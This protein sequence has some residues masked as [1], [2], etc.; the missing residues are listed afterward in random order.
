M[1]VHYGSAL[2][3]LTAEQKEEQASRSQSYARRNQR[4]HVYLTD[5]RQLK[6]L[7]MGIH[8]YRT[9]A[10]NVFDEDQKAVTVKVGEEK[11]KEEDIERSRQASRVNGETSSLQNG[12]TVLQR[13][14]LIH[15]T[16]GKFKS[17]GTLPS[18]TKMIRE[19]QTRVIRSR[20]GVSFSGDV[21]PR[22]LDE[23]VEWALKEKN[24]S[25]LLQ[26]LFS[27]DDQMTRYRK[28]RK[29]ALERFKALH[30]RAP[31]DLDEFVSFLVDVDVEEDGGSGNFKASPPQNAISPGA[32]NSHPAG[33]HEPGGNGGTMLSLA[34]RLEQL[35]EAGDETLKRRFRETVP[36]PSISPGDDRPAP[37]GVGSRRRYSLKNCDNGSHQ[38]QFSPPTVISRGQANPN[39]G[40]Q[41]QQQQ[42]GSTDEA[43][44]HSTSH[45]ASKEISSL[46]AHV[47][48][49]CQEN[50]T[51]S[52]AV[53]PKKQS[54]P[55]RPTPRAATYHQRRVE[56]DTLA[57]QPTVYSNDPNPT[58]RKEHQDISVRAAVSAA[59]SQMKAFHAELHDKLEDFR[60]IDSRILGKCEQVLRGK[61]R[62]TL[63]SYRIC[64]SFYKF[65]E[66]LD[67]D[68]QS[69]QQKVD[70]KDFLRPESM[71]MIMSN[72]K[73]FE[74][75]HFMRDL[76]LME[77]RVNS[78]R[79]FKALERLH[80]ASWVF[81][82]FP[83][84]REMHRRAPGGNIPPAALLF[85]SAVLNVI[86][87]GWDLDQASF[88]RILEGAVLHSD[89]YSKS[90]VHRVVSLV[91][92]VVGI[93][94]EHFLR[95]LTARDIPASPELTA[96]IRANRAKRRIA[97]KRSITT[98]SSLR[99]IFDQGG[100]PLSAV[101]NL[102]GLSVCEMEDDFSDD[103][104]RHSLHVV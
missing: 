44:G 34:R 91:R 6:D 16:K 65:D 25:V 22:T 41:Q 87:H 13:L 17:H 36:S 95:Y 5:P 83:K 84:L 67:V 97:A 27:L 24:E 77:I 20:T 37:G 19:S 57:P 98:R 75:R 50:H 45:A 33:F 1:E 100:S 53:I 74:N 29:L 54:E 89:D 11:T 4:R 94:P 49:P 79:S 82:F 31:L 59:A 86:M 10:P 101:L 88:Y 18:F 56:A 64:D 76:R 69:L 35:K 39:F 15:N 71:D 70:D 93:S 63:G 9:T 30:R 26:K 103:D 47:T 73:L 55:S 72:L 58:S 81:D 52:Q 96:L 61:E 92:E 8:L 68:V 43:A 42:Q 28:E 60:R 66:A 46:R 21:K 2:E 104:S 40:Q 102:Q 14:R 12:P 23:T 85:I 80:E 32:S 90:T 51:T 48:P 7:L 3:K 38:Q 99:P 62:F 78:V